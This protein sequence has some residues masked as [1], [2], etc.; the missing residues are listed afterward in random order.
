M[1]SLLAIHHEGS[2]LI[3]GSEN[4]ANPERAFPAFLLQTKNFTLRCLVDARDVQ[5]SQRLIGITEAQKCSLGLKS[6]HYG[7]KRLT[8]AL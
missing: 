1:G 8:G 4:V 3:H 6:D 7:S 5:L 2:G